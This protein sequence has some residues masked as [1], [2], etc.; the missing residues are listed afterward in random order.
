MPI[1]HV[2]PDTLHATPNYSHA[3]VA[4]GPLVLVS[5]QIGLDRAGNLVGPGDIE[6]QATQV[7]R[8]LETALAAAGTHLDQVVRL[9]VLITD[10]ANIPA[11]RA[12][13]DRFFQPPW[14]ASTLMVCGLAREELLIE[15]EATALLPEG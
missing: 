15:V 8:N 9:G 1:R 2:H 10:R 14:P 11:W 5:G 4:H 13:R 7:L 6:A 3:V 12:V